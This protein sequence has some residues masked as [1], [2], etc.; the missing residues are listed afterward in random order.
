MTPE[1]AAWIESDVLRRQAI[2]EDILDERGR[3]EALV[4]DGELPFTCADPKVPELRKLPVLMEEVGEVAAELQ[5]DATERERL[6]NELIQ[7]AAVAVAW[8]ESL[9]EGG[10]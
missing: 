6:Y 3:Q 9:K 5:G 1:I 10:Q 2:M 4:R 7:V 8:A